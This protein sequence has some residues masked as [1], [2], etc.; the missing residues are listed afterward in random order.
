MSNSVSI[1]PGVSILSVLS[2]LNYK[3]WFALAEFVDNS[4]QSYF[5]N[6]GRLKELHGDSYKLIVKIEIDP[7]D[8][9]TISVRDNAAGIHEED[10]ERAFRAAEVP[11]NREGLSEFGMG[12]K[13]AACWFSPFWRVRTSALGEKTEKSILFDIKKIVDDKVE[14]LQAD[15]IEAPEER[16]FTEIMLTNLH[17]IP[18]GR[19]IGKIKEHLRSIY[20]EFT[21]RG[22]LEL[23]FDSEL[24]VYDEV[25]VLFAPHYKRLGEESIHWKKEI[26]YDFGDDLQVAGFAAIMETANASGAGFALFRRG[27]LIEGSNDEGFRPEI[28]FGKPN[29]FAYQRVFGELH[30]TGFEVSHTKDGFQWDENS[31]VFL[32]M[33]KEQLQQ[34]PLPILSQARE[35]R[36]KLNPDKVK[37]A[38]EVA[39]E[40]TASALEKTVPDMAP[41]LRDEPLVGAPPENLSKASTT[42]HRIID[43]DVRGENWK[44][45]L[46][47]TSDPAVGN[48][49]ELSDIPFPEEGSGDDDCRKLALRVS[50]THPFTERFGGAD[51][52]QIEPLLRM[53]AALGLSETL[54][55]DG[56]VKMAG[57]IR[58]NVN[59]LL[60]ALAN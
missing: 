56:G 37:A 52:Y 31:D 18:H 8:G 22:D 17:K 40:R 27:R 21:R 38:A 14:E 57:T 25:P 6:E 30:L 41:R 53:A 23:Y 34:E 51:A 2:H 3:P 44:I 50:L 26:K 15:L 46:E 35:H 33:L 48:W 11:P 9:G 1:R 32:K 55:R 7:N 39:T 20:R 36:M 13:S 58:R 47:L 54:A 49:L 19:T 29:S 60:R 59:E 42:S 45:L 43:V 24:L 5:Q 12:M 28:I 10:Y 4:L 16:H